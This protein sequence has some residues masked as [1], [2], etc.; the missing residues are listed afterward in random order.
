MDSH[1]ECLRKLDELS[2]SL[3]KL[4]TKDD[5]LVALLGVVAMGVFA[6]VAFAV[7]WGA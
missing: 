1:K 5:G 2:G 4:P 7:L 6:V 3:D